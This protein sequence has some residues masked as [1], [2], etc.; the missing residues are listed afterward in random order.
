MDH[1][2]DKKYRDVSTTH[3]PI[4]LNGN[5]NPTSGQGFNVHNYSRFSKCGFGYI[6]LL[7]FIYSRFLSTG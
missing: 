3:R 1:S 2:D 4:D 6:Y 5:Q 7:L